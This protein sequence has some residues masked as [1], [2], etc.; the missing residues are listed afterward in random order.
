MT[1]PWAA[2]TVGVG[3]SGAQEHYRLRL[4]V[5]GQT[6]KSLSALSNLRRTCEQH[7]EIMPASESAGPPDGS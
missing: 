3:D 2:A 7:L 5:A 6:S 1:D 4:Y